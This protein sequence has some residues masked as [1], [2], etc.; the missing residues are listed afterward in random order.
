MVSFIIIFSTVSYGTYNKGPSFVSFWTLSLHQAQKDKGICSWV[1][2]EMPTWEYNLNF[3][4]VFQIR[5][6]LIYFSNIF[7]IYFSLIYMPQLSWNSIV[8]Y[9]SN[10]KQISLIIIK[11][12]RHFFIWSDFLY[13]TTQLWYKWRNNTPHFQ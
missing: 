9:K 12:K 4:T 8:W 13:M 5:F 10:E 3:L 7:Q 2:R 1:Y 6:S 11:N